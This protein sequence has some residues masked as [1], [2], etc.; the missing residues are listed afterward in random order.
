MDTVFPGLSL[1]IVIGA[2]MAL[3]M[4]SINQPL[5]IGHIL[6]GIIVGPAV[7]HV[8]KSPDT[9]ALF[10]D[11]G[12]ALLLFIIGLGLNPQIIK[13][14]SRTAA[15]VG[16]IQVSS[17]TALGWGLGHALGLSN[18]SAAFLGASLAFSSTIIILKMLSDKHEQSR[19]YGKIAIS[20]S[21]V[22]DMIA[23]AL[24]VLTS[25]GS[26][27]SLAVGTAVELAIKGSL[28]G[29]IIYWISSRLL[30]QF[31]RLIADSQEFL[32]LF[33][34]A[35]G[36]GAAA[37]FQKIG[38][39]SE[40]GALLG[41]ICLASQPYAQEISARLR[42]LR[43]FFV[44]VFFIALGANLNLHHLG[45]MFG[46]IVVSAL[47]V[48]IA[49][50]LISMAVMGYLGYTKRTGF[51]ASVA[52]AQVSE[53]SIVLVLLAEKRGLIDSSLVT[54]ITFIALTSI[55]ASSYLIIFSDEL[56]RFFERFLN[57]FERSETH[58]EIATPHNYE[59]VLFG[60][61]KGGHEFVK[62]FRQMTKNFV[63]IDY[64]PEVIDILEQRKIRHL[65]GDATD[66][67]LLEEA[68][69]AKAKLIV[70]TITDPEANSFLLNFLKHKGS[71]AVVIAEADNPKEAGKLYDEGASYVILPH[72]IGGQ[73]ISAFVK[74]SGFRKSDFK[75][76]REQHIRYLKRQHGVGQRQAKRQKLGH[77]VVENLTALTA[78][79]SK[80]TK[81]S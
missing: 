9:L 25:A 80:S 54:A 60:Y 56:F 42:P 32:F 57:I 8:A 68:N 4:R 52:L 30:P 58:G 66:A 79:R 69:I 64:D 1:I 41:G 21:L 70:S 3:L 12:I 2:A 45:P 11:L 67:E 10:S 48:I 29:V 26:S 39:S 77:T 13:E 59:M 23:I 47:I 50:P 36:L 40:I 17:I 51:K 55:A 5:I 7:F 49:K 63:V 15:Y 19:L 27:K 34:I 73:K 20:V 14:V 24:V 22:Q 46:T 33:A 65:Y 62:V 16:V 35:W 61:Q 37:L 78:P 38:L 75:R 71:D 43:D 76:I 31:H 74:K 18:T 44:I 28:I 6:T 72:F 53:F 81:A